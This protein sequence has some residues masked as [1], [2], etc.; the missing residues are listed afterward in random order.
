MDCLYPDVAVSIPIL[1]RHYPLFVVSNCVEDYLARFRADTGLGKYIKDAE[2]F[3]ATRLPKGENISRVLRRNQVQRA[4]YI[5][6]T[7]G[8][9]I[10]AR[11]AGA[12]FY[13]VT[14]GF[15]QPA[16]DCMSFDSFGQV[17]DFFVSLAE[18]S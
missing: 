14:Y 17:R 2:C 15:G 13:F 4:A 8:D 7:A 5:G 1:A 16:Q 6:D 12:D 18:R 3:G 9:Q 10:A 11:Q